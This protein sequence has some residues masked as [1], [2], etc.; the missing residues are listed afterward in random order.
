MIKARRPERGVT[1][2]E[3]VGAIV[4]AAALVVAISLVILKDNRVGVAVCKA[5]HSITRT[6]GQCGPGSQS[7][8]VTDQDFQPDKCKVGETGA[9]YNAKVKI[10]FIQFG[11]D[12]GFV[13]TRFSDGTVQLTATDGRSL[14]AA[15]GVGADVSFGKLTGGAKVDFGGGLQFD[16]GSTW[17][18]PG[19]NG[20]QDADAFRSDL[21]TYLI[22]QQAM[23]EGGNC[24]TMCVDVR[25]PDVN[26]AT[27]KLTGDLSGTLGINLSNK[28][29]NPPPDTSD[30]GETLPAAQVVAKISGGSTWAVRTDNNTGDQTYSTTLSLSGSTTS[31]LFTKTWGTS[32]ATDVTMS[33][34]KNSDGK[35]TGISFVS[36]AKGAA[37]NGGKASGSSDASDGST[38]GGSVSADQDRSRATVITTALQ[39]SPDD[40]DAQRTAS[41]WLAGTGGDFSWP[42][43]ITAG[44]IDPSLGSTTDPFQQLMHDQAKVSAITYDNV[45]D[46]Y[47]FGANVKIGVAL[48]FDFSLENSESDAIDASYL[49]APDADGRRSPI[50]YTDCVN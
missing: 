34:T 33:V 40:A 12:G 16:Y 7:A 48:G 6:G 24:L 1:T 11:S 41:N 39:I 32:D 5:V 25:R 19:K 2:L 9:T 35:I 22:Q 49:G 44:T 23:Q 36:T 10:L 14:G 13:E 46:A 21:N 18:F 43:A 50:A 29:G 38:K 20:Q 37:K 42:G 8:P 17:T 45:K 30:P 47:A 28:S 27:T 4:I 26:V 3:Y 31:Q 15:G